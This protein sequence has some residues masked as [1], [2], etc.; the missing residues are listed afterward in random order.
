MDTIHTNTDSHTFLTSHWWTQSRLPRLSW[1]AAQSYYKITNIITIECVQHKQIR[2][3]DWCNAYNVY[4]SIF[5]RQI[6]LDS[7]FLISSLPRAY[8]ADVVDFGL[9]LTNCLE[10]IYGWIVLRSLYIDIGLLHSYYVYTSIAVFVADDNCLFNVEEK[11]VILLLDIER[12]LLCPWRPGRHI[13]NEKCDH[14][15]Y[16]DRLKNRNRFLSNFPSKNIIQWGHRY[17]Y[18]YHKYSRKSCCSS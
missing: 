16:Q 5:C 18:H 13:A 1:T 2:I 11:Y 14:S 10:F 12:L 17:I 15:F 4:K 3:R 6:H 7:I 9:K 8:S